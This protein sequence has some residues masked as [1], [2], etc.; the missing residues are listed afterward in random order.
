VFTFNGLHENYFIGD[1]GSMKLIQREKAK[2]DYEMYSGS[3]K[4]KLE[5]G[6]A[7]S[8]KKEIELKAFAMTFKLGAELS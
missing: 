1:F 5:T 8:L 3:K 4:E 6:A 2:M 7:N